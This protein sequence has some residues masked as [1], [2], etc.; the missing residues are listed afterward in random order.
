MTTQALFYF[1]PKPVQ[2]LTS[3]HFPLVIK[4]YCYST[5]SPG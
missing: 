4:F 1:N 5:E 3:T 2:E